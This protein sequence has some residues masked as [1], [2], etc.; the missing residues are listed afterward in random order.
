MEGLDCFG[1]FDWGGLIQTAGNAA[2]FGVTAYQKSEADKK[3]ASDQASALKRAIEAD[4]NAS[5]AVA[6]ARAS[7]QGKTPTAA[8]DQMAAQT[9]VAAQDRAGVGLNSESSRKRAEAAERALAEAIK[10]AQAAPKDIYKA[11]LV[12]AWTQTVNKAQNTTIVTQP[13]PTGLPPAAPES[14]FTRPVLGPI[15]G[16][17]VLL[18]SAGLATGVGLLVKKFFFSK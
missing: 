11:A 8:V 9:A 12:A 3:A 5:V 1:A 15:P 14:W 10:N 18:G 16:Y 2:Q 4:A 6:R 17:G 7:E 13:S